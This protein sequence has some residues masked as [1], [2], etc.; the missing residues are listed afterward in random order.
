MAWWSWGMTKRFGGALLVALA[1]VPACS[2]DD[3]SPPQPAM[4][5][6]LPTDLGVDTQNCGSCGHI[7]AGISA[8][9]VQGVCGCP[10]Q[11]GTCVN[12]CDDL[13][14]DPLNCGSC[15]NAC[16][17]GFACVNGSCGCA[18]ESLCAGQ[19][20]DLENDPN[21][22]GSCGDACGAKQ[23]CLGG[24]CIGMCTT[25]ADCGA[26][27]VCNAPVWL[28]LD[29]TT[30]CHSN[31]DCSS[32]TTEYCGLG[33]CFAQGS[34]LYTFM[35]PDSGCA[36]GTETSNPSL[37]TCTDH[38]QTCSPT[39]PCPNA[40]L[41]LAMTPNAV[42]GTCVETTDAATPLLDAGSSPDTGA[43]DAGGPSDASTVQQGDSATTLDSA[44]LD[45]AVLDSAV[46]D[47]TVV[48]G[49][50]VDSQPAAIDAAFDATMADG[51]SA[52]DA[53]SDSGST[54]EAEDDTSA[55]DS[56]GVS[57]DDASS[58]DAMSTASSGDAGTDGGP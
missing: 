29:G 40:W 6:G 44:V 37:T 32:P 57:L 20:T 27:Q 11:A 58:D 5:N 13:S 9:C 21:N 12:G 43:S 14:S 42:D 54:D 18:N 38:F 49:A 25:N 35:A 46:A 39:M 2:S 34:R 50:V 16:G 1:A 23:R 56:S 22:C 55:D 45:S 48:D 26:G 52:Q 33:R 19:C 17:Q 31:L 30:A 7:C 41:C 10:A 53:S 15:G 4:C 24:S 28:C 8:V 36:P 3:S 51:A 47:S